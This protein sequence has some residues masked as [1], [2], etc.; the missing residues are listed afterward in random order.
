MDGL[1]VI[2]KPPGPTSH[3]VVARMRRVLGERRIGHTGT[4]DPGASG[5]LPLVIG[6]ATRLA[7]FMSGADK[8][9]EATIR[10]G[11]ST[12]SADAQGIPV[13]PAHAGLLPDATVIDAALGAFRGTFDQQPPAFSAKKIHGTRSYRL[14]RAR[15]PRSSRGSDQGSDPGTDQGTDQG[16]DPGTDRGTDRGSDPGSD[17][18]LPKAVRVTAHSIELLAVDAADVRLRVHC[19]AGFYIRSLAHDL[20]QRLGTGAHLTS[21]RRTRAGAHALEASLPLDAAERDPR[22]ARDRVLP[23][24]GLLP[25]LD[26]VALTPEGVRRAA[27]GCDLGAGDLDGPPPGG[28][29]PVRL[30]DREGQLVGIAYAVSGRAL[31]HPSVILM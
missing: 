2:D 9:Y 22:Q 29:S 5:V 20:G 16:S 12:D 10:L 1:L 28:E 18:V 27:H 14:A 13:G 8:V 24:S 11:V 15:P 23:L 17:P 30:L 31:L 6:R 26:A 25:W 4:L 7:Q 3:D 21:L 19:S